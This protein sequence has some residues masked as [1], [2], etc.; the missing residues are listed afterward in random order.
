ME[1][2]LFHII[3]IEESLTDNLKH[4]GR[5]KGRERHRSLNRRREN[6]LTEGHGQHL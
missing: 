3:I 5:E 1:N 6:I 4:E 2:Q